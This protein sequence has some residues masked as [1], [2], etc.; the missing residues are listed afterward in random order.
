[1]YNPSIPNSRL[2]INSADLLELPD[3][4]EGLHSHVL[5]AS[6]SKALEKVLDSFVSRVDHLLNKVK[7]VNMGG[8]HLMTRED[9]DL[10]LLISMLKRFR[11]KYRVDI[12]LEPGSA[13]AWRS[14]GLITTILDVVDNGGVKPAI[15]DASFTCHMPYA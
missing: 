15:I 3:R 13:I 14:E 2:G 9:Y 1:M 8:G 10:K 4:V 6:D 12:I 7:W 11:S 5:Y